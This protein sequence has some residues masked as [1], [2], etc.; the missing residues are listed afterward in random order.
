[1]VIKS[2][3]YVLKDQNGSIR[4]V[5]KVTSMS[6]EDRLYR[7]LQD[8]K[9]ITRR[10]VCIWIRSLQKK[11][12]TPTIEVVLEVE[13]DGCKEEMQLIAKLR[14]EGARL[15]NGTDG[16]DGALGIK[17]N[18]KT[19]KAVAQANKQRVWTQEMREKHSRARRAAIMP[20][21]YGQRV[22]HGRKRS[23]KARAHAIAQKGRIFLEE[24]RRKISE[25]VKARLKQHPRIA[26]HV[27]KIAEAL[28][29]NKP[30]T[31]HPDK[32]HYAS[33]L[34]RTCYGTSWYRE[35]HQLPATS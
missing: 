14:S 19:R 25:A 34:C 3:V 32:K 16:G 30:A 13:G 23:A 35:K 9:K 12:F 29:Q 4:Y 6:I 21:D 20:A 15:V 17:I 5:G 2:K 18:A 8:A 11:G 22:S 7:H 26:E 27:A 33:G 1:M 24:H 28:R 31:C 10:R